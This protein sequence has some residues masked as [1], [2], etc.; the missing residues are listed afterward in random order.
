MFFRIG[1]VGSLGVNGGKHKKTPEKPYLRVE[2][3]V[4]WVQKGIESILRIFS[5]TS[6]TIH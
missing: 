2:P 6:W 1:K 4:M 5:N 3:K